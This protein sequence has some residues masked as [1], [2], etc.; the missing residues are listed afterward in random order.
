[1]LSVLGVFAC[2]N[3]IGGMSTK[4]ETRDTINAVL[5]KASSGE[6]F[7][8]YLLKRR[9]DDTTDSLTVT[10]EATATAKNGTIELGDFV[11]V[12]WGHVISNG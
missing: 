9:E 6:Q 5:E 8:P 12:E 3:P 11:V 7:E 10:T 4:I 1:A 2:A